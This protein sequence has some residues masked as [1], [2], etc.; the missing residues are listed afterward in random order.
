MQEYMVL[1]DSP[2]AYD[3]RVLARLEPQAGFR[4]QDRWTDSATAAW[5]MDMQTASEIRANLR[6]N[7]PRI[8][9]AEKA[10]KTMLERN[11]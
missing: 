7:N 4:H 1:T 6:F 9:R 10:E 8:V 5:R 2:H 11:I 3:K